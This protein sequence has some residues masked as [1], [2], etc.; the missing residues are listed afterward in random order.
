MLPLADFLQDAAFG[1]RAF[2]TPQ[3]TIQGFIILDMNFCHPIPSLR[4]R[5]GVFI[6]ICGWDPNG[7]DQTHLVSN[8]ERGYSNMHRL[9]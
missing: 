9:L 7:I 5:A 8:N 4:Y 2:K 3:C 6:H 1:A